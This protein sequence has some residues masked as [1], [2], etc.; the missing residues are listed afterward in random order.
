VTWAGG[1]SLWTNRFLL[2]AT[3]VELVLLLAFVGI[4]ALAGLLGGAWPG[5]LGWAAAAA[6]VPTV[7]LADLAYKH[8]ARR[9][10]RG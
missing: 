1:K 4:P 2:V 3:G 9:L 10:V 6:A 5:G 7:L 8:R